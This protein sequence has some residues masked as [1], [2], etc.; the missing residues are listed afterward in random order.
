MKMGSRYPHQS[1]VS[2]LGIM[3]GRPA[4]DAGVPTIVVMQLAAGTVEKA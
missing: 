3:D 1:Q 4:H 2:T